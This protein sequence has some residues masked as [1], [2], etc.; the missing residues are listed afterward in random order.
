MPLKFCSRTKN[1]IS[2]DMVTFRINVEQLKRRKEFISS[3]FISK[4]F[5]DNVP[6]QYAYLGVLG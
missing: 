1:Y 6:V 4:Q 3:W 2:R 5:N